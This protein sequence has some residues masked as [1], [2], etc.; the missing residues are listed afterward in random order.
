MPTTAPLLLLLGLVGAPPVED[1][2]GGAP[3]PP[4]VYSGRAN[5]LDVAVPRLAGAGVEIDGQMSEPEWAQAA[6]LTG[7]SQ[8]SPSDGVAAQDSTEVL[9]WYSATAIHFGVRAFERHGAVNATLADRD[10]IFG[11][12][13]VQIL[14][15]TFDDGR[16]ALVFSVNP[17]GV[18]ADGT[19]VETGQRNSGGFTAGP[20]REQAD[21]SQDFVYQSKGRVTAAGYEVEIRVPFKSIRYQSAE[22]QHW[23]FNVVR[24]VQHSGY[25]DSWAPAKR[26]G[27]SFLAQ[28]G[29]LTGLTDLRRGLVLDAIP[30]VTQRTAGEARLGAAG[31]RDGWRYDAGRPEL[32]GNV[33]WG[34][35]NN[36]TLNGTANPDFSQVEADAGQVVFDPRQAL[37]F[38]ERRPFFLDGIEEF[39]VPSRLIYTRNIVQPVAAAKLTGK[40][41]G[42]NLAF[43]SAVDDR[44]TSRTGSH[45][46]FNVLRV[47]R[48]I[49]R[50]SRLGVAYTDKVDGSNYNRVA[51]VDGRLVFG[52][53]Y[54]AQFQLA[55]SRT[56]RGAALLDGPLW[57]AQIARNGRRLNVNYRLEG[58]DPDFRTESGFIS[59]PGVVN[60]RL[61]H[62][63]TFFGPAGALVENITVGPTVSGTWQYRRFTRRGD[64][65]DKKLHLNSN[66]QLRGG[67]QV[68]ASVLIESF[69]YDPQL[70]AGY[71]I[72]RGLPGGGADTVPFTGTPR[73][74]NL[75]YVISLGTPQ[76]KR[77]S[78]DGRVI[79]G[80]DE[81]FFEWASSD[82][83]F[84][85]LNADVRP[86]EKLRVNARY[87]QQQYDRRTDGSTVGVRRIPRLKV[88][89]QIARPIFVRVVGQYDS[90][91]QDALRDDSR[92]GFPL[93]VYDAA[94]RDYARAGPAANRQ[95][96]ADYL[97]SYQPNPGTVVFAGYGSTMNDPFALDRARSQLERASDGFFLKASYLFRL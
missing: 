64:M 46:V 27:A 42:T 36:L 13:Y 74:P 38:P 88:E 91:R 10:R 80:R 78:A 28:S 61:D 8:F 6:V 7:F 17:L 20:A 45:P 57:N 1:P 24:R 30:T 31:A 86:T 52:R 68:G 59:R 53:I 12:D 15:S 50:Q 72:E 3:P 79:W 67:W 19:L 49:G 33:R 65:Q 21:L 89:Y 40:V 56:Q 60:G 23:G 54:N 41:A 9:V 76:F 62:R 26:A 25:E 94:L 92:T 63:V 85:E 81:N 11:D 75:D 51:D 82:I 58:I 18:Q 29:K 37:F 66:G 4:T 84:V 35:T 55:A 69:G 5:Q 90:N 77:F 43:L 73:I 93:L 39:T 70:Y 14:V 44:V 96:R 32:G 16:Q 48:D 87:V 22:V 97:F 47:Q 2:P 95:F 71:A 34:V 83:L